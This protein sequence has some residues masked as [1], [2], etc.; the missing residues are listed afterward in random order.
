MGIESVYQSS[1][2]GEPLFTVV[3]HNAADD[4]DDGG[5]DDTVKLCWLNTSD[6]LAAGK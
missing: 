6:R 2:W 5:D 3:R 4:D 1:Y